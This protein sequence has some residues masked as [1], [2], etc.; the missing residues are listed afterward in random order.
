MF[1]G[2]TTSFSPVDQRFGGLLDIGYL[3]NV[4]QCLNEQP[5]VGWLD[6]LVGFRFWLVSGGFWLVSGWFL[7]GFSWFPVG[8]PINRQW[9]AG[10]LIALLQ[11]STHT[12]V[13]TKKPPTVHTTNTS[14]TIA[15]RFPFVT[16]SRYTR[17]SLAAMGQ[18]EVEAIATVDLRCDS[19]TST[20]YRE[21]TTRMRCSEIMESEEFAHFAELMQRIA[22][23]RHQRAIAS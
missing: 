18:H 10:F 13:Y 9:L 8:P 3:L 2:S 17:E 5:M 6:W 16:P 21:S 11:K 7:V 23:Q 19:A 14:T 12:F 4:Q 20:G 22:T 1:G 15:T